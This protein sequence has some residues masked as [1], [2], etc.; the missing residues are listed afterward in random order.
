MCCSKRF[1]TQ[2]LSS[3]INRLVM[4]Y[5]YSLLLLI[6]LGSLFVT[7]YIGDHF[8][9]TTN[10]KLEQTGLSRTT[11]GDLKDDVLD[12]IHYTQKDILIVVSCIFGG[13]V[14]LLTIVLFSI[15][16]SLEQGFSDV[17]YAIDFTVQETG[18]TIGQTTEQIS[19][20][21]HSIVRPLAKTFNDTL[22]RIKQ[23]QMKEVQITTHELI[24][25]LP[26]EI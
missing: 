8:I 13:A 16:T 5:G 10:S 3:Q 21:I 15:S 11:I 14:I 25:H 12:N 18:E 20:K 17:Q 2:K 23:E 6:T 1:N 9:R 26:D 19:P 22:A 24:N 7:W 4:G